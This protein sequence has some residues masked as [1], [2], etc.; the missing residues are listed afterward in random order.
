LEIRYKK[1]NALFLTSIACEPY[2][3]CLPTPLLVQ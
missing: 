3:P 2:T 1:I